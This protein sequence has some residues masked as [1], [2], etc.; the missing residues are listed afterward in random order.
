MLDWLVESQNGF[1]KGYGQIGI[2]VGVLSPKAAMGQHVESQY[3]VPRIELHPL[4]GLAL[5]KQLLRQFSSGFNF[6]LQVPRLYSYLPS[7]ADIADLGFG[8]DFSFSCA[9]GALNL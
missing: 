3:H 1:F 2:E 9:F 8:V 5:E 4:F 6:Y 7:F